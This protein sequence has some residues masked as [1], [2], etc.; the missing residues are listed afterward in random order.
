MRDTAKTKQQLVDE[1]VALRKRVAELEAAEVERKQAEEALRKTEKEFRYVLDNS[2]D[3]IYRLNL[4][5]GTYDYVSPA[6]KRLLGYSPEEMI[7]LGFEQIRLMSHPDDVELLAR[8]AERLAAR[9]F[10]LTDENAP[11]TS[12]FRV[13]HKELG[14]RWVSDT[15]TVAFDEQN[16]PV[17]L[18]G[19]LHDITE[20]KMAEGVLRA[21]EQ[22]LKDAMALGQTG[23]WEF[24]V[25]TQKI[26]WSEEVFRFFERDPSLGNP[27]AEEEATYY[28]REQA[29][30]LREYARRA[31]E[32]GEAVQYDFVATLPGRG[33]AQ[34]MGFMRPIKDASGRVV[35]LFG[36]FHDIT[37]RKMA[38]E[39]L[40]ESEEKYRAV[41]NE[42]GDGI[43][44]IDFETGLIQ[45]CNP[46]FERQTGRSLDRLRK[47]RPWELRPPQYVEAARA[48][49]SEIKAEGSGGSADLPYLKPDGEIVP[50]EFRARVVTIGATRYVQTVTRDITKRRQAEEALRHSEEYFRALIENAQEGVIVLN[51]DGSIRYE[52]PSSP[53]VF[54]YEP[55]DG[56][57]QNPMSA[58]EP[59]DI[60]GAADAFAQLSERPGTTV[61]REVRVRAKDGSV[62]TIEV[63]GKSL[64]DN[65]AVAGIVVNFRNI[66]E[67]RQAEEALH[68]SEVYFRALIENA[69][70]A[71]IVLNKDG[72][73][74]YESPSAERVLG[75]TPEQRVGKSPFEMV[76]PDD[77]PFAAEAFA[78][79][80]REP[81][82]T[83]HVE[84]RARKKD[85][86]LATLEIV[87]RNLLDDPAV[88]GIVAN[89]RDIT[90]RKN[91]ERALRESEQKYRLL[92]ENVTDI[93]WAVDMEARPLYVS[94]SITRLLG[95]ERDEAMS[96]GVRDMLTPAALEAATKLL[97]EEFLTRRAH[98]EAEPEEV[99]LEGEAYHKDGHLVWVET[100]FSFLA[101][102]SGHITGIVGVT[103]DIRE[104][105]Q[106]EVELRLRDKAIDNSLNA[107]AMSDMGGRI[108]YVNRACVKMWGKGTREELVG[109]PYWELLSPGDA[110]RAKEIAKAMF[111]KG[112]W[113]G[114]LVGTREDGT[115]L[116]IEVLSSLARDDQGN[117][118]QTIS[119]FVDITDRKKAEE[120]LR[121]S[122]QHYSALVGNLTDAVFKFKGGVI[123][124][125]N[126][127]V[128]E[129][130][131][132]PREELLGKPATF[133]YPTDMSQREYVKAVSTT[134]KERGLFRGGGKFRRK[135]G[136]FVDIEYSL[137]QIPGKDPIE[138]LVVGRDVT[139]RVR[140]EESLRESE[141]N[142]RSVLENARDVIYRLNLSAGTYDYMSPSSKEVFGYTPEECTALGFDGMGALVHPD[143]ME[144]LV[145]DLEKLGARVLGVTQGNV[146]AISE[147]RF[148]HKELGYR[149]FSDTR[150]VV[151]DEN[152]TPVAAVG[153]VRD[154]TESK[155]Y[156]QHLEGVVEERT[157]EL[158][159]AQEQLV[160]RERLAVLG[161]LAG[162]IGHELRNPLGAIKNACYFLNMVLERPDPEVKETLGIVDREVATCERIISSLLDFARQRPPAR[163]K[164]HLNSV[165][166]EALSRTRVPKNVE[167]VTRLDETLPPVMAD[168]AQLDQVFGNILLNAVQSMPNGGRLAVE[169]GVRGP[170]WVAVSIADTGVGIL[171][172]NIA[173]L[174]EPLFSTKARG[175]GLGL[176][177]SKTIVEAHGGSVEVQSEAGKGSTFTVKL[178]V[179]G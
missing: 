58:V 62:R 89:F 120:A 94:P 22:R 128:E 38:E 9:I 170:G 24:E 21:S 96:K 93:V 145:H 124:W 135:D 162:G 63:L 177:L 104:R 154:I 51:R 49:F 148:K 102:P 73:I 174:F 163:R 109:R 36:V 100:R 142:F 178:P 81:G 57:R 111:G 50:V 149:W 146:A 46:E 115:G 129:I 79:S 167:V 85:G 55:E 66:T 72:T 103:R 25:D 92:A 175:I 13:H 56:I 16:M 2:V 151:C 99:T 125:C 20:R 169:S 152:N 35:R 7:A 171:S 121:E 67:R 91:A 173:R 138:V 60:A 6:S 31:M 157:R 132:Y 168:S 101:D 75:V 32:Q 40:R 82:G 126:D 155:Q 39:A 4:H 1:V 130:Y 160:R 11:A 110:V 18:V 107:V 140:A 141:G 71:V 144:R 27:T 68:K 117:P 118:L 53:R 113:S 76:H 61:R 5:T 108:T 161:Q 3:M 48:K 143:D 164:S 15:R 65:P 14:Y 127:R 70:E 134:I 23:Y 150:S 165:V 123:V 54:G 159:D 77:F 98:L 172:E 105:K 158:T 95:Y 139:E 97:T 29:G 8:D 88:G 80:L 28:S 78:R 42:A 47:L 112:F 64:L 90:E 74:L 19:I 34:M 43:A 119:S 166:L 30:R 45:E 153:S 122:E 33:P 87:G 86:S 17:A 83:M 156:S 137:T 84:V 116:C 136:S 59:E 12:E 147:Y 176:P 114:E 52:S 26:S 179:G 69:M 106:A 41:F 131:G 44:L 10:G 133:F 37:E